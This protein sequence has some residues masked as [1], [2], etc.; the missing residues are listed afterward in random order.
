M[1]VRSTFIVLMLICIHEIF[2]MLWCLLACVV[3]VPKAVGKKQTTPTETPTW[4]HQE[5]ANSCLVLFVY[6]L[7]YLPEVLLIN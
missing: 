6:S 4:W 2:E 1:Y 5:A 3:F 7:Y